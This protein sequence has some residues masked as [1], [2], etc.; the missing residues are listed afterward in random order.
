MIDLFSLASGPLAT[1]NPMQPATLRTATG[2]KVASDYSVGSTYQDVP[3]WVDVQAMATSELAQV[4]NINQQSEQRAAY[5]QRP[6]HGLNRALQTGGD[7]IIINGAEWLVTQVLEPW[8]D[9]AGAPTSTITTQQQ[10][11][12]EWCKVLLTRQIPS[13]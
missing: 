4:S 11:G 1:I 9:G 10:G 8:G 12:A 3:I 7:R 5:V 13:P 2:P 6:L